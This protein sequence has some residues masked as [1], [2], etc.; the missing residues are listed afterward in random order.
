MRPAASDR[1]D[2]GISGCV[3]AI[4]ADGGFV[5][6]RI[7][8]SSGLSIIRCP[9]RASSR[10]TASTQQELFHLGDV[11]AGFFEDLLAHARTQLADREFVVGGDLFDGRQRGHAGGADVAVKLAMMM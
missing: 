9:R 8:F 7:E 1:D 2:G 11:I 5:G 3:E 4:V 6:T 10:R